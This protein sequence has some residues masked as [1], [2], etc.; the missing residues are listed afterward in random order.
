MTD[1]TAKTISLSAQKTANAR[2][3]FM[4]PSIVTGGVIVLLFCVAGGIRQA[5]VRH[6]RQ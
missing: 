3:R 6:Y 2:S 1:A 5:T 4:K